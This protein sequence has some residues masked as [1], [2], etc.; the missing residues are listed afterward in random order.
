[1]F[2]GVLGNDLTSKGLYIWDLRANLVSKYSNHTEF[3]F[4]EG[5]IYASEFHI[6][7]VNQPIRPIRY[8]NLGQ[9]KDDTCDVSTGK[10][11]HGPLNMSCKPVQ[12][13]GKAPLGPDSSYIIELRTG[14]GALVDPVS[15]MI[16]LD[17]MPKSIKQQQEFFSRPLLLLSGR[18]PSGKPLPIMALEEVSIQGTAYSEF[19]KQYVFLTTR[20]TDGVPGHTTIWPK[21]QPQPVYLVN[22]DGGG[23]AIHIPSHRDWN[24]IHLAMAA[25]PGLVF[26]GSGAYA[27]EWGGIFLQDGKSAWVLDRGKAEALA[28]S[29]DGCKAAY[30]IFKDYGKTKIDIASVKSIDFCK[31]G[32]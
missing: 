27:N 13:R 12:F 10:G 16:V 23:R 32:G 28:V 4:A 21:H 15:R 30:A 3:C 26:I 20:P 17:R 31:G 29:P 8:G 11:C 6:E 14:D 22:K 18:Y 7:R 2:V 9:E 24:K 25:V 1:M 5:Y 19:D